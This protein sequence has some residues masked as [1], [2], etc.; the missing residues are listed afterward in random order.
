VLS[1]RKVRRMGN[2]ERL[3]WIETHKRKITNLGFQW[4]LSH[5]LRK[6][7]LQKMNLERLDKKELAAMVNH[8]ILADGRIWLFST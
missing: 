6:I 3:S 7:D 4:L 8:E 1:N 2:S 5:N